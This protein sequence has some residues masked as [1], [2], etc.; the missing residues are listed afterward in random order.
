MQRLLKITLFIFTLF[1]NSITTANSTPPQL[2][3]KLIQH[4]LKKNLA[5]D[6]YWLALL[7]LPKSPSLLSPFNSEITSKNFFLSPQGSRDPKAELI[8]T[9]HAFFAIPEPN[10]P[11]SSCRF[12]ARYHWLKK[13]LDW[14]KK[15]PIVCPKFDQF[16]QQGNIKSIS[17]IFA[18]GY[19]SN[20]ASFYGHVLLK[21]NQQKNGKEHIE[22][23][24]KSL[25]YGAIVPKGENSLIYVLK[26]LFGGYDA[27]FSDDVFYRQNHI[28]IE[29]EL[30]DL[31][32]YRLNLTQAQVNQLVYHAWELL[33]AKFQY[34]FLNKNCAYAMADLLEL[35]INQPLKSNSPIWALPIDLFNRLNSTT[36]KH[37]P[38][39]KEI[40]Y[41]PSRQS[42]FQQRYQHLSEGKKSQLNM[43]ANDPDF[44]LTQLNTLTEAEQINIID[45]LLDYYAFRLLDNDDKEEIKNKKQRLLLH[46]IQLRATSAADTPTFSVQPPTSGPLPLMLRLG[47]QQSAQQAANLNLTTR[48]SYYDL[49][50]L[51][52]GRLPNTQLTTLELKL[53]LKKE[54]LVFQRLDFFHIQNLNVSQSGLKKDGGW[55]W[56]ARFFADNQ[57]DDCSFCPKLNLQMGMGKATKWGEHLIVYAMTD[58]T[59]STHQTA[60]TRLRITPYL[61][62][63]MSINSHWKSQFILR[64]SYDGNGKRSSDNESQW[65]NRFG[66]S[67]KWDLRLDYEQHNDTNN[68]TTALSLYW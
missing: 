23:L 42:Q 56:K 12:I 34:Y 40:H 30:R 18:T 52:A 19:L 41:I 60:Q 37:P 44:S 50:N 67:R 39:V 33:G 6:P 9:L 43:I 32:E 53:I 7:H 61:G 35:V 25:N 16:K 31:W 15:T 20:P 21:F 17:L 36:K 38:L 29:N 51:E 10:K 22:L 48:L 65:Q 2:Q 59:L 46:R 63:L 57:G 68:I 54:Q 66:N 28:Y 1:Y 58:L 4:A 64:S 26:G 24:D 49:L 5:S 14:P 8:A 45:S 11:A 27:S 62:L 3:N 13:Q 47:I 55:A